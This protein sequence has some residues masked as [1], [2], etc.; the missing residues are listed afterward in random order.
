MAHGRRAQ[1]QEKISG[2][3]GDVLSMLYLI[4]CT[5]KRYE[6]QG[7]I[8][9]RPAADPLGGARHDLHRAAKRSTGILSNFP[10]KWMAHAAALDHLP[11]RHVVPPAA[12][13]AQPRVRAQIALAARRGARPA[14]RRH[15]R[16]KSEATPPACSK[17]R[18]T[19]PSPASR[20]TRSCARR[21]RRARWCRNQESDL[22]TLARENDLITAEESASGSARKRCA[23]RHQ[24]RRLPQD[25]GR[26]E[27]AA[28][29]LDSRRGQGGLTCSPNQSTSSTARARRSSSRRT[30]PARSPRATSRRRPGA[31]CSCARSSRPTELD[32]V[33]LGCAAPSVDEVNIGRVAALRMG[34]GQK[35]P[36]L[37]GD[38]Q[39]RLRHAGDRLRH[40]QHPRRPLEPGARRRRATRCRA[41]R[42]STTTRWCNWF[43]D[44]AA[45][46]TLRPKNCACL[47]DCPSARC[48]HRSSAS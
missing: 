4:S 19:P 5:L 41:R 28:E 18:S 9:G 34:C 25:F 38:A 46:Q 16:A 26:A 40:Q 23:K 48:S 12:R 32:E 36:G 20:S 15:V 1:A 10:V 27:I 33:I 29:A 13:C 22:G 31:R 8:G 2:R 24:G 43:S 44:M 14:D 11:A 42:C 3:L 7:R 37:D 30:V 39:L 35:G 45:A 17:R 47:Q 6:D 21:S